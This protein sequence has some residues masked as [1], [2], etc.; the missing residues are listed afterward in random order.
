LSGLYSAGGGLENFKIIAY[1][2][3]I[4]AVESQSVK[5]NITVEFLI[6]LTLYYCGEV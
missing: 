6:I 3:V 2:K 1:T 5:Y 4:T